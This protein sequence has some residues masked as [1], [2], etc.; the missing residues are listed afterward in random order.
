MFLLLFLKDLDELMASM[1]KSTPEAIWATTNKGKSFAELSFKFLRVLGVL[2]VGCLKG[3]VQVCGLGGYRVFPGL[4]I[5]WFMLEHYFYLEQI[6]FDNLTDMEKKKDIVYLL[7]MYI[8]QKINKQEEV[9]KKLPNQFTF[10]YFI[11]QLA[12]KIVKLF[13]NYSQS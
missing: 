13:V 7:V 12:I 1:C 3:A 4:R 11:A 6:K 5:L 2:G 8:Q 9:S 10:V